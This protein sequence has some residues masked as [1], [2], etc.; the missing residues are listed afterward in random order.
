MKNF[1]Y[2]IVQYFRNLYLNW[3]TK[4]ADRLKAKSDKS[5]LKLKAFMA[6]YSFDYSSR[7]PQESQDLFELIDKTST[8]VR[9]Q[10]IVLGK[11]PDMVLPA[12]VPTTNDIKKEPATLNAMNNY[13]DHCVKNPKI[14]PIIQSRLNYE[15][16]QQKIKE[17]R[18]K[19]S[20]EVNVEI[21]SDVNQNDTFNKSE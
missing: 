11:N 4:R 12:P 13:F 5:E 15:A 10:L 14:H 9:Q 8:A 19:A 20:Q 3:L 16:R 7:E 21:K 17:D 1:Y 18:L 6:K 2:K